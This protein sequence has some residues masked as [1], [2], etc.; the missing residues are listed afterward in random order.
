MD[1][2]D[3]KLERITYDQIHRFHS[4]E[5]PPR[6]IAAVT[7]TLADMRLNIEDVS[8][9][10]LQSEFCGLFVVTGADHPDQGKLG[11][12]LQKAT[13][14]LGLTFHIRKMENTAVNETPSPVNPLS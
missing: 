11:D 8:Q 7:R 6:I 1:D 14:H 3:K 5:R 2:R 13:S 12:A 9:T 10:I 4:G